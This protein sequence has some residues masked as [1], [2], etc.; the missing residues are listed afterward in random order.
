MKVGERVNNLVRLFN[1]REGLTRDLDT[2]PKRFFSESLEDGPNRGRVVRLD[3]LMAEY[4][5][6]RGWD[7]DGVPGKK[8]LE[9]LGI[10][11]N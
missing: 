10:D 11:A 4:Y 6:V 2:L 9:E 7:E 8:K 5:M 3:Q 1:I